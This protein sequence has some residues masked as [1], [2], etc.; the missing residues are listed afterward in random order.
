MQAVGGSC[1]TWALCGSHARDKLAD[2]GGEFIGVPREY[3]SGFEHLA[4]NIAVPIR[5]FLDSCNCF[6]NLSRD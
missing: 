2:F 3:D 5:S 4:C 6:C 1:L